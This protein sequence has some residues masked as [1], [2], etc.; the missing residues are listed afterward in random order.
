M[1]FISTDTVKAKRQAIKKALPA[2]KFSITIHDYS[3]IRCIIKS[4]PIA[5]LDEGVTDECVNKYYIEDHYAEKPEVLDVL[6]TIQSILS[7]GNHT[8]SIDGDYGNIP[9]YYTSLNIG[10]WDKGYEI[11]K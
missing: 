7:D 3:S 5:M 10:S 4:G 2:F 8:E 11:I 1:P 9:K 6:L